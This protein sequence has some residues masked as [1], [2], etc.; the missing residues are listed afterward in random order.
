MLGNPNIAEEALRR[1]Y[2]LTKGC[3]LYLKLIREGDAEALKARSRFTTAEVNLLL[4]SRD[5]VS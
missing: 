5:V 4:F 2:L 1:I 3:P